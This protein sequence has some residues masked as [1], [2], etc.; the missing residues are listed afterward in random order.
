NNYFFAP[1]LQ[2]QATQEVANVQQIG[3]EDIPTTE[4]FYDVEGKNFA[5]YGVRVGEGIITLPSKSKSPKSLFAGGK[6]FFCIQ[7]GKQGAPTLYGENQNVRALS[8]TLGALPSEISLITNLD[9]Q[10]E[11][12]GLTAK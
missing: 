3:I 6:E 1:K 7:G 11:L 10:G 5:C 9:Q 12:K 8:K 2:Q 4:L